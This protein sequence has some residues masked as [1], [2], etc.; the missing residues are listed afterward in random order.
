MVSVSILQTHEPKNLRSFIAQANK[1]IRAEIT[2]EIKVERK[3]FSEEMMKK[4]KL[5]K[6]KRLIKIPKGA[7]KEGLIKII[8]DNKKHFKDIKKNV[9]KQDKIKELDIEIKNETPKIKNMNSSQLN[10]LSKKYMNY[11]ELVGLDNKKHKGIVKAIFKRQQELKK[12]SLPKITITEA[13]EEKGGGPADP[14]SKLPPIPKPLT[15]IRIAPKK[16]AEEKKQEDTPQESMRKRRERIIKKFPQDTAPKRDLKR[17]Y[18]DN[19][20]KF[21]KPDAIKGFVDNPFILIKNTGLKNNKL[22]FE[23]LN[24]DQAEKGV[25]KF[26]KASYSIKGTPTNKFESINLKLPDIPKD[27]IEKFLSTANTAGTEQI[28]VKAIAAIRKGLKEIEVQYKNNDTKKLIERTQNIYKREYEK[29][30]INQKKKAEPKAKLG[31]SGVGQKRK[32]ETKPSK[33]KVIDVPTRSP[34]ARVFNRGGKFFKPKEKK[35]EAGPA[36]EAPKLTD[37]R[38][39]QIIQKVQDLGKLKVEEKRKIADALELLALEEKMKKPVKEKKGKKPKAPEDELAR[40]PFMIEAIKNSRKRGNPALGLELQLQE[41]DK[42]FDLSEF[43]L[44]FG[45]AAEKPKA[46]DKAKPADKPKKKKKKE[47]TLQR[48]RRERAEAIEKDKGKIIPAIKDFSKNGQNEFFKYLKATNE[49]GFTLEDQSDLLDNMEDL[50]DKLP[51]ERKARQELNQF[52]KEEMILFNALFPKEYI[53]Y[54]E[55]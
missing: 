46:A 44:P 12:P 53:Q 23:W 6:E 13:E 43:E 38:K 21:S 39:N 37:T 15:K 7:K 32:R 34:K 5:E 26:N 30:K 51:K 17:L 41:L 24:V 14:K 25:T 16:K 9:T 4:R 28:G 3:K 2:A 1:N 47:T 19:K 22:V 54:I 48:I 50:A 52:D 10:E 35:E 29:F 36:Q 20:S 8:M 31:E 45:G 40:I 55:L 18:N 49:D 42:Q 33:K 27:E 11:K